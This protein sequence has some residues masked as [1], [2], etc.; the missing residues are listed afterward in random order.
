MLWRPGNNRLLDVQ[1]LL[2]YPSFKLVH[3]AVLN[4]KTQGVKKLQPLPLIVLVQEDVRG[5]LVCAK[6]VVDVRAG[7]RPPENAPSNTSTPST[8]RENR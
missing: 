8:R 2:A 1:D 7:M 3:C 4:V 6:Q 5:E